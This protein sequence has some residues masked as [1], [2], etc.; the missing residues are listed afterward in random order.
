MNLQ[1]LA[2]YL[3]II[4]IILGIT[5]TILVIIQAKGRILVGLWVAVALI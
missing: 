1:P 3:S 2:P 5:L 4:E